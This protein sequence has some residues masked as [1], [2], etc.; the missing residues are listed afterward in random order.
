MQSRATIGPQS[1]PLDVVYS[2]MLASCYEAIKSKSQAREALAA[3]SGTQPPRPTVGAIQ[4]F[5]SGTA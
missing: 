3:A 1:A 2:K 5:V 4:P